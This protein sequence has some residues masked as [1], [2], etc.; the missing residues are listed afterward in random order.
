MSDS[1]LDEL[2]LSY[3]GLSDTVPEKT[4][5]KYPQSGV[6]SR[7][8]DRR[9]R[10]RR[11]FR[12]G[13]AAQEAPLYRGKS[14]AVTIYLSSNVDGVVSFLEANGVSARNVGEDYIEAFV[15]VLLLAETSEQPGVL[16]VQVIQPPE[17]FEAFSTV[18]G[19]GPELHGSP[20]LEPS[21][22]PRARHQGGG[23]RC[24]LRGHPLAYGIRIVR[25][26]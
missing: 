18:P 8:A 25:K 10:G 7:R 11:N 24:G 22:V 19:N 17:S 2:G 14:V 13:G 16:W 20:S 12:G 3:C 23:N 21:R 6:R 1:D 15:P 5:L 26:R 4:E 9:N